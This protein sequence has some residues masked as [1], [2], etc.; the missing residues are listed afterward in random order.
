MADELNQSELKHYIKLYQSVLEQILDDV[1]DL[2]DE[3]GKQPTGCAGWSIKDHIS[4]V[5]GLE[6]SLGGAPEPDL[7]VPDYDHVS[8][9]FARYMELHVEARR[10][11]PIIAIVD[12]L[13]TLIPRR[14]GQVEVA[15]AQGNIEVAGP[16]GTT[17]KLSSI[18][19]IRVL[20]LYAHQL[21]ISRALDKPSKIDG[22]VADFVMDRCFGAW[23]AI[24][25]RKANV[26]GS[27]TLGTTEPHPHQQTI[28]LSDKSDRDS[29]Q[30]SLIGSRDTMLKLAMGRGNLDEVLAEAEVSGD[31]ALLD[32][33][34]P[35]LAFTP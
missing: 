30:A 34:K 14:V 13:T 19:P 15:A 26:E 18:I 2:D 17:S 4:H 32:A 5:V 9:D 12:E 31:S 33:A 24:L 23:S 35:H 28:K 7:E 22:P 20:D 27:L 29:T 11:L 8:G 6:Q 3:H 25:P 1:R 10:S 21:D 16:M